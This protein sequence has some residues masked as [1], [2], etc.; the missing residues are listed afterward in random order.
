MVKINF[1]LQKSSLSP[2]PY[3]K[4][5]NSFPVYFIDTS[6]LTLQLPLLNSCQADIKIYKDGRHDKSRD[7]RPLYVECNDGEDQP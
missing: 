1:F 6:K 3:P 7:C 2:F 5:P 4:C